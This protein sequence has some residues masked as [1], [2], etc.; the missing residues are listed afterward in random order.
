MSKGDTMRPML[1]AL[2]LVLVSASTAEAQDRPPVRV[3]GRPVI[4]P[5]PPDPSRDIPRPPVGVPSPTPRVVVPVP[6]VPIPAGAPT[7]PPRDPSTWR[8]GLPAPADVEPFSAAW[9]ER[10]KA[11][12]K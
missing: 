2:V 7:P 3:D 10:Y 6:S 8:P 1:L 5:A 4:Q 12:K 11:L 9:W